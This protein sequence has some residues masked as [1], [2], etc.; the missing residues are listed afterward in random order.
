MGLRLGVAAGTTRGFNEEEFATIGQWIADVIDA[1]AKGD[2]AAAA[3][4][5][6]AEVAKLCEAHPIYG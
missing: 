2:G 4:R 3:A 1:E 5:V 6:G